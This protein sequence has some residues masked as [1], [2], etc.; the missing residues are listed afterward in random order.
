MLRFVSRLGAIAL[1][2]AFTSA[3]ARAGLVITEV[4]SSS[5]TGGTGDWFELTNTG[6]GT[7]DLTGYKMDDNSFNSALSVALT[8]VPSLAAGATAVFIE[9][10]DTDVAA[11]RTFWGGS[12]ATAT[13]GDYSGAGV[14]LS[15]TADGVTLFDSTGTEI[16]GI[17]VSFGAATSGSSFGYH[18]GVFGGVS[19]NGVDGAFQSV[20]TPTN[21]GSP[22]VAPEPAALALVGVGATALRRRRR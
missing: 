19:Q 20:G 21:T 3:S 9:G 15:S 12:V 2:V 7:V 1:A 6:P 17:R 22:G 8:G 16:P 10:T 4:M 5:G 11:F 13:I 18:N 14:G